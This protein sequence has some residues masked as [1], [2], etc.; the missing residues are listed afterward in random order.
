M[1]L[2]DKSATNVDY[3]DN[4]PVNRTIVL[5]DIK[6]D[7][8]YHLSHPGLTLHTSAVGI[9]RG[10]VW[11]SRLDK[12]FRVSG[13][14]L[15]DVDTGITVISQDISGINQVSMPYSFQTQGVL[16]DGRFWLYDGATITENIDTDLGK[17]IDAIFG[18]GIYIFTDGEFIYHT[19]ADSEIA[20]DPLTF[21]TN[22]FSPD[23]TKGLLWSNQGQ[24]VVFDRY[25]TNYMDDGGGDNFRFRWIKGKQSRVGIV[26][27]HCKTELDGQMFILGNREEESPSIHILTG[28]EITIA[29]REIDKIL[30]TYT[31]SELAKAVLESRVQERDKFLIVR[32][33]RHTLLYNLTIGQQVGN[34]HAWTILK[35]DV[36]GDA[37]WRAING[38]YDPNQSKWI[39]G[40]SL[41]NKLG[42]LDNTTNLQYGEI[43]EE[44]FYT[45]MIPLEARSINSL[46]MDSLPGFAAAEVNLFLS[47]SLDGV[48]H[49]QEYPIP[50][51]TPNDYNIKV[52]TEPLG[53][54]PLNFS[55][56]F[57]IVA[58]GRTAFSDLRIDH[59]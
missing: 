42:Y 49:G 8:G 37:P 55:F 14:S 54:I 4:L 41:D 21:A 23:K 46:M 56:K 59:D 22:E 57:R 11:N 53:Y 44:L 26:G 20:I 9:D 34:K 33:K 28:G 1:G 17:P 2:G 5:R 47:M 7:Q 58:N 50:I 52:R 27:T 15:I 16:S 32:L 6:G 48:A 25:S 45:P 13:N 43:I 18:S 31:E 24:L 10:A 36:L 3:R 39:Y 30:A 29:T 35:T 38:I 19:R 51:S 12:H 40:D